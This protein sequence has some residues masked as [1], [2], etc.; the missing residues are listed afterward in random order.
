MFQI[1]FGKF[2]SSLRKEKNLTQDELAEKLNISSGKTI[3]KWENG[4]SIPDFET[5]IQLSKEFDI[6]LYE[7]S[8]C[9]KIKDKNITK[10]DISKIIDKKQLKKISLKKSLLFTSIVIITIISIIS[11]IYTILNYNTTKVYTLESQNSEFIIDGTYTKTKDY[12]V[13]AI[14][15]V[16]YVG[17]DKTL[18]LTKVSDYNY[19]LFNNSD[20]MYNYKLA[21]TIDLNSETTL[22]KLLL[23]TNILID[24]NEF[25]I[26]PDGKINN[27]TLI[28]YYLD[29]NKNEI[30]HTIPI[31]LI[32]QSTN[33]K[34]S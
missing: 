22:N 29:M 20:I 25:Y 6:S 17:E 14:T 31:K 8:I 27:L 23:T 15:K 11:F 12:S 21:K 19:T 16:Y 30:Q 2:I 18:P 5:I 10:E 32:K 9:E 28:I 24:S 1:E 7:L 34:M 3:S 13:L 33:D 26:T 4:N